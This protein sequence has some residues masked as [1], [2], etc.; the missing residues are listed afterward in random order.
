MST[1][2]VVLKWKEDN[3]SRPISSAGLTE[4]AKRTGIEP[5]LIVDIEWVPGTFTRYADKPV[6]GSSGLILSASSVDEVINLETGSNRASIELTLDDTDGVIKGL[7]D[8]YDIHK[9]TVIVRQYFAGL[10]ISDAFEVFRGQIHSPIVWSE[11]TRD[12]SFSVYSMVFTTEAGFSPEEGQFPEIPEDLIGKTWPMCFGTPIHVPATKVKQTLTTAAMTSGGI[13]DATLPLKKEIL[14]YRLAQ[15]LE[16]YSY[17][18][19]LIG[20][21]KGIEVPAQ[22]LQDEYT[23][24]IIAHDILKQTFEDIAVELEKIQLMIAELIQEY[25]DLDGEDRTEIETRLTSLRT[26]RDERVTVLKGL[27]NQLDVYEKTDEIFAIRVDNLKFEI[28]LVNKLRQH[29]VRLKQDYAQFSAE[30]ASVKDAIST[31]NVVFGAVLE[32]S[33][34]YR[35]PQNQNTTVIANN[36]RMTGVFNNNR[37]TIGAPQTTYDQ[38][39]LGARETDEP[40]ILWLGPDVSANLNLNGMF[41]YS[42]KG[43][44]TRVVQQEGNKLK[45]QLPKKNRSSRTRKRNIDYSDDNDSRVK[46]IF[47]ATLSRLLSGGETDEQIAQIAND[48]PKTVN[49]KVYKALTGGDT[50]TAFRVV[51]TGV[52]EDGDPTS[53]LSTSSFRLKYGEYYLTESILFSDDEET[54]KEKIL[55]CTDLLPETAI[56]VTIVETFGGNATTIE[57]SISDVIPH[58]FTLFDVNLQVADTYEKRDNVSLQYVP[59]KDGL[60][61]TLGVD[62]G[63]LKAGKEGTIT[64]SGQITFYF[65]GKALVIQSPFLFSAQ[66]LVDKLETDGLLEAGE[67][68]ANGGEWPNDDDVYEDLVFTCTQKN[69][70][71]FID[72]SKVV[73][74]YE[75]DDVNNPDVLGVPRPIVTFSGYASEYTNN[76][77]AEKLQSA[78]DKISVASGLTKFKERFAELLKERKEQAKN[79]EIDYGVQQALTQVSETISKILSTVDKV[80]AEDIYRVISDREYELLYEMEVA[81]YLQFANELKELDTTF[82][83]DDAYEFTAKNFGNTVEVAPIILPKW[84]QS[85]YNTT[86]QYRR[87]QLIEALPRSTEG[88]YIGVGESIVSGTGFQEKYVAN[89]LPSTIRSV[90]AYRNISGVQRLVPVPTSYYVTDEA[91]DYGSYTCT[92][93][94]ISKPLQWFDKSWVGDD[95]FITLTSSVG[96]NVVDVIEWIAETYTNLVIDSTSFDH[97]RTLQENYPVNFAV[98]EKKNALELIEDIAWQARCVCWIARGNLYIRYLPEKFDP[99]KTITQDDIAESSLKLTFTETE[100]LITKFTA[101]WRETYVQKEPYRTIVRRNVKKYEEITEDKEFYIYNNR[102][103]VVK[104]L[105]FWAI[106]RGTTWRRAMFTVYLNHLDLETQDIVELDI[107][108]NYIT[109]G[110]INAIIEKADYDSSQN[111]IALTCWLPV[112]A[113]EKTEYKFFWPKDLTITDFYPLPEEIISGNAGNPINIQVPSGEDYD[114]YDPTL[115]DQRPKDFGGI[116][117]S[118]SGDL[119]PASIAEELTQLDYQLDQIST[120][121]LSEDDGWKNVLD[122]PLQGYLPTLIGSSKNVGLL[123]KGGSHLGQ[124]IEEFYKEHSSEFLPETYS[125]DLGIYYAKIML[126]NGRQVYAYAFDASVRVKTGD[127]VLVFVIDKGI[128]DITYDDEGQEKKF[129]IPG[130][131]YIKPTNAPAMD[132]DE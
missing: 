117:P 26:Q 10:D 70:S 60:V 14:E 1:A 53:N 102:D 94:T 120:T 113:H 92:T 79:G 28:N 9:R 104:S 38:V 50:S 78:A 85:V 48:I 101:R 54:I 16:A 67:V 111:T 17:Y 72:M 90:Y 23:Q 95:I 45:I 130:L 88:F 81:G 91:E 105:T 115:L 43:Y 11:G 132:V 77:I 37:F 123:P 5:I 29:C 128:L 129:Y 3:L 41:L 124:V 27:R 87:M 57:V 76:E 83:E 51:L 116:K 73:C 62:Y 122:D 106:R 114:P 86:N 44:I 103:L 74:D 99:V 108:Y 24:H 121:E 15:I 34:G 36:L 42:D 47:D 46:T 80:E 98:L 19:Q 7:M 64:L 84:L 110:A 109:D 33:S 56:S 89:I 100:Q 2:V 66:D 75:E 96:P 71:I 127:K 61:Y 125:K 22:Q 31:Q 6:D 68:T 4:I 131:T 35:F 32:T 69:K 12:V 30:L 25:N 63:G 55:A 112:Q 8:Q 40:D 39:V 107:S 59:Q 65:S 58:R 20:V 119:P 118:D 52:G 18:L 97:V 13:P 82:T 93:I 49:P 126:A 21:A